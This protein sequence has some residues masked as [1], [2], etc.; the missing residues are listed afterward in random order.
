MHYVHV[1]EVVNSRGGP[2]DYFITSEQIYKE[3]LLK[4]KRGYNVDV[5]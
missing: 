2:F 3:K 4:A 5:L 1:T